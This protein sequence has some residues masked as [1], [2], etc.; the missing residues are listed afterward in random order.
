[1]NVV[2]AA[3]QYEKKYNFFTQK[4]TPR[5]CGSSKTDS[6]LR[7]FSNYDHV[8]FRLK[9]DLGCDYVPT[10]Y[11]G[12]IHVSL[13][14]HSLFSSLKLAEIEKIKINGT[15]SLV[16]LQPSPVVSLTLLYVSSDVSLAYHSAIYVKIPIPLPVSCSHNSLL[17]E[18][19]FLVSAFPTGV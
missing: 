6:R 9:C 12:L 15:F 2:D 8:K 16:T 10:V 19:N 4:C 17:V 3:A 13:L 18:H 5:G 7:H 14:E 11:L 1:M